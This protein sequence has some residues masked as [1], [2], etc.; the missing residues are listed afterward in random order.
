MS[1][2]I[3]TKEFSTIAVGTLVTGIVLQKGIFS[4][5]CQLCEFIAGFPIWT[6]E[7]G[8]LGFAGWLQ[9][10]A[11]AQHPDLSPYKDS[12]LPYKE[13]AAQLVFQ[14]GESIPFTKGNGERRLDPLT[15]LVVGI[16][17]LSSLPNEE[18]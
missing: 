11:I 12:K 1:E 7:Y 6:H 2:T 18:S 10:L 13:L 5:M 16:S 3:E 15:T 14:F 17:P 4:E 8:N 9:N